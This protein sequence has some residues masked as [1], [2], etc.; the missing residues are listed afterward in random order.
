MDT[1]HSEGLQAPP[2]PFP[3]A[4]FLSKTCDCLVS[5]LGPASSRNLCLPSPSLPEARSRG[6]ELAD[7]PP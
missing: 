5:T 2:G 7:Q 6:L 1:V 3:E 4:W